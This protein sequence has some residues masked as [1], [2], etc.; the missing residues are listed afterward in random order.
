M[1][2]RSTSG[3]SPLCARRFGLHPL[4]Q[5]EP[6]WWLRHAP[7][8]VRRV[9]PLLREGRATLGEV[10]QDL[11]GDAEAVKIAL[12]ANLG[13]YHDD[14]DR[15]AF[16]TYAVAQASYLTGGGHYV[17]GGSAALTN[18]LVEL[19]REAGGVVE[20]GR[21]VNTLLINRSGI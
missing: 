1:V 14:P 18:A 21:E 3:A 10:L 20:A 19:I 11:F 2:C 4:H 15:M 8:G 12:A 13:Y 17:R 9:W 5:E 6:S 7:E 16:L